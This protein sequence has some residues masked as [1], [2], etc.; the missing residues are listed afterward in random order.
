[1]DCTL[2]QIGAAG[3]NDFMG[4]TI[5]EGSLCLP[6]NYNPPI[7]IDANGIIEDAIGAP[8]VTKLYSPGLS[9]NL[10]TDFFLFGHGISPSCIIV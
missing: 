2:L 3:M 7:L 10:Q 4:D 8:W 5:E 6:A 9:G 1:M